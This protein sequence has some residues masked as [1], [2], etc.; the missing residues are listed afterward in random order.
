M[1]RKLFSII[2][3]KMISQIKL[4]KRL[5]HIA[6]HISKGAYFAD[7]GSDH[8]YLPCYVCLS[9]PTVHAIAGEVREGP[10]QRA[11]ETV[12]YY[13]L[14]NQIQVR[15][16][17]GLD[18]IDEKVNEVVIAGMGGSLI[19]KIISN[20]SK[21]LPII[22]RFILQPNNHENYV[23]ETLR[24]HK[25]FLSNEIILEENNHIYE[26][27]IADR[28]SPDP[29]ETSLQHKQILFG[30]LLLEEKSPIFIKKWLNERTN[31]LRVIHNIQ[32]SNVQDKRRLAHFKKQLQW[33]EEVLQL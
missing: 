11:L 19:S 2:G 18:V 13:Q 10:Y 3:G 14:H 12:N 30:P 24:K 32:Q 9:D 26:I 22:Q 23:R 33:I 15:L 4:S 1:Y 28:F 5:Q 17:D 6:E 31:I 27:L 20:G 29:Y 25:Y 7:I 16:G 8:A 21:K